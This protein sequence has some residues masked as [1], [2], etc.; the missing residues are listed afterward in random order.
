ME[1]IDARMAA[2]PAQPSLPRAVSGLAAMRRA[3]KDFE[4]VFL[5]EMLKPMFAGL[6]AEPPFG[7]GMAEETWR[8]LQIAEFGKAV[9][10][11]GGLGLADAI[12]REMLTW[13]EGKPT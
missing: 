8:S 9:A 6:D 3:A 10:A 5:A 2:L 11:C 12:L 4:G 1:A 7:G 13:Q